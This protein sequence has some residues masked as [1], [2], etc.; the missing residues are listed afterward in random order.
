MSDFVLNLVADGGYLGIMLL[1]CLETVF[2]PIPSELIMTL[3]GFEVAEGRLGLVGVIAAGTAGAMAG[4]IFWYWVAVVIGIDRFRPLVRRWG[5]WITLS[6]RD[7]DRGHDWFETHGGP[8]VLFGRMLPTLRSLVSVP[9]GLMRM[10][11][12]RFVIYSTIGTAGWSAML[13]TAGYKLGE[14]VDVDA[15]AGPLS[16]AVIVVLLAGYVWRVATWKPD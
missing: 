2:P 7:L 1:M 12:R 8:V 16:T 5:R 4:N 10:T 15:L 9:A 14:S 3:G 11:F 6:V 13:A